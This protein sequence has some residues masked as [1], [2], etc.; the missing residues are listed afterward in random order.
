MS[1]AVFIYNLVSAPVI[2][3][4]G[5]FG[6][7]FLSGLTLFIHQFTY[8][9]PNNEPAKTIRRMMVGSMLR[10]IMAI[11]FLLITLI[12]FKPVNIPFVILY[13]LVFSILMVFEIYSIRCKLRPDSKDRSK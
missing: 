11:L 2:P 7:L 4:Y 12:S 6:I 5:Y 1:L 3:A 8:G 10:M 9:N 13:I